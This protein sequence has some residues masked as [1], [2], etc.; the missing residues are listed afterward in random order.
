MARVLAIS[1]QVAR[2]HVGLSAIVPI[3]QALGHDVVALPT[4]VLSN[5]PGHVHVAGERIAPDQLRRMLAALAANGWLHDIDAVLTGYLPSAEHVQF[6]IEAIETIKRLNPLAVILVDPVLGDE[7]E[8]LY[9]DACAARAI[10]RDLMPRAGIV[11]LN[12]FELGWLSGRTI[13]DARS[14]AAASQAMRWP[15]TVATS[16]GPMPRTP[17]PKTLVNA[18]LE[19]GEIIAT[20][21]AERLN[22]VPNG[23]GDLFSALLLGHAVMTKKDTA[24]RDTLAAFRRA[25]A[26]VEFAVRKSTGRP[27]LQLIAN[28]RAVVSASPE[29]TR[30]GDT[31]LGPRV[32]GPCVAGVDACRAGW[33]VVL[34]N[35]D[36]DLA[37]RARIVATFADILALPEAPQIIAIDIPI[38]LPEHTGIGGRAADIA[39]RAKLGARQS[40]VF[41]VPARAAI[42]E[43]EYRAACAVAL[44]HSQ[45]PRKVSKQI[46]N[47]F[48]K[49]RE[50]DALMSPA[51]QARVYETHPELAFWALNGERPLDEAKK[52]GSRP[53]GPGLALR[54]GLLA[55]AGYDPGFLGGN[56][57]F[58]ASAAGPDDLLDAAV[59]AWSAARIALGHGRRFPTDP[60]LDAKGLRMEIWG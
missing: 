47:L 35:I 13:T 42:M 32:L 59:C 43:T 16:L 22:A 44:A 25:C 8:G 38:G 45:P 55:G 34:A 36:G 50:I 29:P 48:P 46:F 51:L 2:G 7:P 9:I 3:L 11:K 57:G 52:V 21:A 14:A 30:R 56:G 40:S 27:E 28:L 58:R 17:L 54:R 31:R 24:N 26:G 60:P 5:H 53:H 41:S 18:Y 15:T 37:P 10:N 6:A 49:I 39:A 20:V 1:S 33:L 19:A 12:C 23:T 4:V